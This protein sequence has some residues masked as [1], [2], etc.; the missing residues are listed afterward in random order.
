MKKSEGPI[1]LNYKIHS[2]VE[3]VFAA[4]TEIDQMKKWFFDNI[5]DFKAEVGFTT[6][7]SVSNEDR[8]FTHLWQVLEVLDNQ[9]IS[10]NWKYM[11]YSGDSN[12]AFLLSEEEN[13]VNLEI[14]IDVLQDFPDEIPEFKRSSCIGGWDYFIGQNLKDYLA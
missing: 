12:I 7:F 13:E 10:Y 14:R 11:E 9:K 8:T 3:K 2:S 1:I 6:S 4:L 5:P